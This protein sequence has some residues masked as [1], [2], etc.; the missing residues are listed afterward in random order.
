MS[1]V[2]ERIK[3]VRKSKGYSVRYL[4]E[5]SGISRSTISR[6]ENNHLNPSEDKLKQIIKALGLSV[7]QFWSEPLAYV[8]TQASD[9]RGIK[10][11]I[12]RIVNDLD[13]IQIA[14]NVLREHYGIEIVMVQKLG[15]DNSVHFRK[16]I[17]KAAKAVSRQATEVDRG[18]TP[19]TRKIFKYDWCEFMQSPKKTESHTYE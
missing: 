16:G 12:D 14:M 9:N 5:L 7:S 4:S 3:E 6:W 2:G 19:L 13:D 18:F 17:D 10:E 8:R 11:Q 1:T 15:T